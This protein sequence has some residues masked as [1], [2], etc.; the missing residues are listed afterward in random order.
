ML[1]E[2]KKYCNIRIADS[3]FRFFRIT[4]LYKISVIIILIHSLIAKENPKMLA[5]VTKYICC[6][7]RTMH[8]KKMIKGIGVVGVLL[9][10][11][12][13]RDFDRT[14]DT[15]SGERILIH[16]DN[17]YLH[18]KKEN[19]IHFDKLALSF[20]KMEDKEF[21]VLTIQPLHLNTRCLKDD[22]E[23]FILK[24]S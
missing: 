21:F 20:E 22:M 6:M 16:I 11:S 13:I 17:Q 7:Q 24:Y 8:N 12:R 2:N 18:F 3:M 14:V 10:G 4:K 5:L 1:Q 9:K 23:R 15:F 19:W